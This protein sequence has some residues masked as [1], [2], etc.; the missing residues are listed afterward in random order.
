MRHA[1]V[2]VVS[3]DGRPQR[4]PTDPV[5]WHYGPVTSEETPD[6][7]C[8]RVTDAD[9]RAA[10]RAWRA[11]AEECAGSPRER[12]LHESFLRIVQTQAQ[13]TALEFRRSH[14]TS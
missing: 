3:Q 14:R 7:L 13:Q 2:R 1:H 11:A 5:D 9:V 6:D 4:V 12:V 8:V 10:K